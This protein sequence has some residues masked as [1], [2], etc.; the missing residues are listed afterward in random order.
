MYCS[1]PSTAAAAD[2]CARFAC[3]HP[4]DDS[5]NANNGWRE[6][7]FEYARWGNG[8][9]PT[10]SQY[11]LMPLKPG[12][13]PG[14]RVRWYTR[15]MGTIGG[16]RGNQGGGGCD[17]P[18]QENGFNG[19]AV[20]KATCVVKWFAGSLRWYCWEGLWTMQTLPG[21]VG[22][23]RL[24][25]SY[26][27]PAPQYVPDPG[28][29]Q[30]HFNIWQANSGA[31][32]WGR[33]V[34]TTITNFQFTTDDANIGNWPG[35]SG[36]SRLLLEEQE[37]SRQ[38]QRSL[39]AADAHWLEQQLEGS[40]LSRKERESLRAHCEELRRIGEE[41]KARGGGNTSAILDWLSTLPESPEH[42]RLMA[43]Y[44]TE[45]GLSSRVLQEATPARYSC[46]DPHTAMLKASG[47]LS[48]ASAATPPLSAGGAGAG[49]G[50]GRASTVSAVLGT[51]GALAGVSLLVAGA[52]VVNNRRRAA[53][54]GGGGVGGTSSLSAAA[55]TAGRKVSDTAKSAAAKVRSAGSQVLPS[56][57]KSSK[58]GE[59]QEE[60]GEEEGGEEETEEEQE[61][62]EPA[63]SSSRASGSS[64]GRTSSRK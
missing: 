1:Y 4:A 41:E 8:G 15:Q 46:G 14:W 31:P 18:G 57:G 44:E 50:A 5:G 3:L 53:A 32:R 7:D 48:A 38:V 37:A 60:G 52:V 26:T 21:A 40:H 49:G 12:N 25:A 36:L 42:R 39:V 63:P 29:N 2:L 59:G 56:A 27:Y 47:V 11:V 30:W 55:S 54:A 64:A 35:N 28:R 51:L 9:D 24:L 13:S 17:D 23:A 58:S 19:A 22:T 34:H 33:R 10:S 20:N 62:A 61:E 43:S 6:I 45:R 16:E